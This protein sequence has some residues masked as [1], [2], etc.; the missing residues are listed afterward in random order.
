MDTSKLVPND[1]RVSWKTASVNG[2]TYRYILSEPQDASRT[3]D[4]ILL[5]HGFPD[6]AFGWRY[7]IPYLTSL[8]FR[9]ICPDMTG[10]AGTDAP[11]DLTHYTHK[12][13]SADMKVLV[14]QIIG[15]GKQI[16][17][18][19][20][21]WGGAQVY[22]Q[23][24]YH[25]E[26]IKAV[27]SVCTPFA[28]PTPTYVS[29][30]EV[31]ETRLPNFAYQLQFAGPDVEEYATGPEQV[32]HIFAA[33]MGGSGPDG[34]K[35]MT[36][37]EGMKLDMMRE[38]GSKLSNSPLLS[39]E[40]VKY[41]VSEYMRHEK[42]PLRGPLN[43]YRTRELNFEDEKQLIEDGKAKIEVPVLFIGA[44][45][46]TALP[47][48]MAAMMDRYLDQLT[49]KEVNAS[50]W[51]LWQAADEVN[52]IVGEWLAKLLPGQIKSSHL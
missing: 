37:R 23:A 43:W 9:I 34:Q 12:S 38:L 20:H 6:L 7:Q 32:R 8:G 28:P 50:H 11:Q 10:Y 46:D 30:K 35:A 27:F 16:I 21:D 39:E 42:S 29:L 25:P 41:Y 26:L 2:K 44:T 49:K 51:A 48:A 1:P 15:E 36:V 13:I 52:G 19:G 4:T 14:E 45:G 33:I 17:L 3:I 40:E 31:V 5:V 47:P 22:R 24:M 18:G